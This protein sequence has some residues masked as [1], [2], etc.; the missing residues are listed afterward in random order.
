MAAARCDAVEDDRARVA[1]LAAPHELGA[2]PLGPRR[3]AARRPRPGTCRRRPSA[4]GGRRPSAGAPTLPIVVVLP[5]PLT[6]T[7]SQTFGQ[8][9]GPG[10][11]C[12]PGRRPARRALMSSWSASSSASGSV[13]SLALTRVAQ[14]VE[15]RVGDPHPDVGPQQRLLEL[16]PRL[17]G[18]RPRGRA[19]RRTPRSSAA[20]ALPIRSRKRGRP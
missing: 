10:S 16:V 3:R 7:N 15:Q 6:P 11:K 4:P 9:A 18:D 13:I 8:P 1:A 2:G 19:R 17:V 14:V 20:R 12:R 5:T